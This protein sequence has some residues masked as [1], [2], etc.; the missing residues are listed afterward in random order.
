MVGLDSGLTERL[1]CAV[2]RRGEPEVAD[3]NTPIIGHEYVARFEVTMNHVG[4][5]SCSQAATS[6]DEVIDDFVPRAMRSSKPARKSCAFDEFHGNEHLAVDK[7]SVVDLHDTRVR[8]SGHCLRFADES[9]VLFRDAPWKQELQCDMA[10]EPRIVGAMNNAHAALTE[11]L[12]KH[13]AA[14]PLPFRFL[15]V[16][17][18]LHRGTFVQA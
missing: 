6:R 2:N 8:E 9:R 4:R 16:V 10:F 17:P 7:A 13:I 5:V 12:E 11:R 1:A 3:Q 18:V 14:K 15:A